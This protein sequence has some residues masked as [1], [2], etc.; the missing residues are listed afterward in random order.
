MSCRY[1]RA[2]SFF[3][4]IVL[5]DKVDHFHTDGRVHSSHVNTTL[6]VI[7]GDLYRR[8]LSSGTRM[9]ADTVRGRGAYRRIK[10]AEVTVLGDPPTATGKAEVPSIIRKVS[11]LSDFRF[12][13]F[14]SR[15]SSNQGCSHC[16]ERKGPIANPIIS[17]SDRFLMCRRKKKYP[18]LHKCFLL[19][20]SSSH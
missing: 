16:R 6:I 11:L 9:A 7:V 4:L 10:P 18:Q 20:A 8:L 3:I 13:H 12:F 1:I 15:L 14:F 2:D 19:F 5:T 17:R